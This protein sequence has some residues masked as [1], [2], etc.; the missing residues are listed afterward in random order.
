MCDPAAIPD[1]VVLAP[2]PAM[3]PGLIVQLPEGNP[4]NAILPVARAQVGCV[5]VPITGFAG[6][7]G[8]TF[9]TILEVAADVHPKSLVTV[10]EYVPDAKPEIVLAEP[11]PA[12]APGLIVQFP[13]GRLFKITLPL[14]TVQV[15]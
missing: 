1:K 12:I 7:A 8:C 9:I 15:G 6:V 11:V 13:E 4:L 3:A 14:A 2:E 5:R 10:Y